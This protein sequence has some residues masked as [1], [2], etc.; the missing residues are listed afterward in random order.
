MNKKKK[1]FSVK[2]T[3]VTEYGTVSASLRFGSLRSAALWC[4]DVRGNDRISVIEIVEV[5]NDC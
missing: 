3:K 2:F 4:K 1:E 5:G